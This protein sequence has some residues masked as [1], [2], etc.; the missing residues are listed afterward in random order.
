MNY[1]DSLFQLNNIVNSGSKYELTKIRRLLQ[2]LDHP[3]NSF[4]MIHIT[5]TKGKGSTGAILSGFLQNSCSCGFFSSPHLISPCERFRIN[6]VQISEEVFSEALTEIWPYILQVESETGSKPS[7]FETCT[8]LAFYLFRKFNVRIGV[9]EVGLG[10]RLDATN[11]ADGKICILTRIHF[12]HTKILGN[13]L[14]QIA[15]EK[16]GIIKKNSLVINVNRKKEILS[17]IEKKTVLENAELLYSGK[18]YQ[19]RVRKSDLHGQVLDIYKNG[20]LFLKNTVFP[21]PGRHQLENLKCALTAYDKL[22][23]F[24][25]LCLSQ[26]DFSNISWPGRLQLIEGDPEIILDGAHNPVSG[27]CLS[28]FLEK[29]LLYKKAIFLFSMLGD[30]DS[31]SFLKSISPFSE[32]IVLTEVNN[33]RK[34]PIS[35]LEQIVRETCRCSIHTAENTVSA[36]ETG[37]DLAR[38]AKLPLIITGSLYLVGECLGILKNQVQVKSQ[39]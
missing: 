39:G 18:Y 28:L 36:L 34:L 16:A 31:R 24:F 23:G 35:Q 27:H 21:L 13:T 32:G 4:F 30:K 3:E 19:I 15:R 22:N 2:L 14:E 37:K 38:K 9:V 29:H 5:G 10:G 33:D 17:E 26:K 11:A 6:N 1:N 25:D 8:A 12:D 7:F 20:K